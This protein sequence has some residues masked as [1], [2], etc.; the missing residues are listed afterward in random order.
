MKYNA[1]IQPSGTEFSVNDD[2]TILESAI[3]SGVYLE[4]SCMNGSCGTC[5][6]KLIQGKLKNG[7]VNASVDG[8]SGK[9]IQEG[10]ILT[11]Q[12]IADSDIELE[13]EFYPELSNIKKSVQPCKVEDL[14]FP[15][16]DIVIIKLRLPPTAKFEYLP[17]QYIQLIVKGNRRSYSI[18]NAH[19]SYQGIE[20][21]IRKVENGLFSDFLFN[22]LK[23]D[24]LLRLEGPLGSF[25]VRENKAPII[26]LAGGTGFAPVKAMV[27]DL[28]SKQSRRD[29]YVYWGASKVPL[30]YSDLPEKWEREKSIVRYVAVLSADDDWIGRKGLVHEAVLEDFNELKDFDV[31]ACGSPAMIEIAR[32][33][34]VLKGLK[35]SN[36]HS[37]AFVSSE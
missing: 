36:F 26:F 8:L 2:K 32:T 16:D 15:D 35:K 24:Q 3:E 22:E 19:S 37:D 34:F 14:C 23:L 29:I 4:Y 33:S 6:S 1:R 13:A 20:L 7:S 27:E 25:F 10:Y 11:C 30:F 17:G 12:A 9:D 5:K 21:H 28:I 31:Y 18:A